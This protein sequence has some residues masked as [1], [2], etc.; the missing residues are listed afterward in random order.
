[1]KKNRINLVF[2]ILSIILI[3]IIGVLY[4]IDYR[5]LTRKSVKYFSKVKI[6]FYGGKDFRIFETDIAYILTLIPIS[7]FLLT[8]KLTLL[9][10]KIKYTM[11]FI[12]SIVSFYCLYTYG[13]SCIIGITI[14]LPTYINGTLMYN[15]NNVDYK[16]IL[17]LTI[18]SSFVVTILAKK[19]I[20]TLGIFQIFNNLKGYINLFVIY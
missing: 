10:T 3:F 14:D 13:E 17:F 15:Y 6:D 12:I 9:S 16:G 1:M 18:V 20:D 19:L 7:L 2:L 5:I 4:E 8:R 11:L